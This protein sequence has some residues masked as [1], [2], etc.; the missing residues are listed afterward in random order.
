MSGAISIPYMHV[1]SPQACMPHAGNNERQG[2]VTE[3]IKSERHENEIVAPKDGSF[4][5][6]H[7]LDQLLCPQKELSSC[8]IGTS[9][10]TGSLVPVE[11]TYQLIHAGQ[12]NLV[13]AMPEHSMH[14]M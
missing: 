6:H 4:T 11:H 7:Q 10:R 1:R 12:Q 5:P 14:A 3:R 2:T 13:H 9:G 8:L